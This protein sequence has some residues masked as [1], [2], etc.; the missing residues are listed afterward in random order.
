[1]SV[2][3]YTDVQF[4]CGLIIKVDDVVWGGVKSL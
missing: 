3:G 4:S 1:M 2:T